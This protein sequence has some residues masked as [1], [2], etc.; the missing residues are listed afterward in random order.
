MK[1]HL[2]FILL[3]IINFSKVEAQQ[4]AQYSQYMNNAYVI[5]PAAGGTEDFMDIKASI[6]KQWVGFAGSPETYYVT[7][8]SPLGRYSGKPH[9]RNKVRNFHTLGGNIYKDVTGPTS[10][11][12]MYGSYSY[13]M[14]LT[15]E[16]RVSMGVFLG[17]QQYKLD[18]NKL[19]F[20]DDGDF[21]GVQSRVVPDGALGSW[22]YSDHF[23]LGLTA[24]QIFQSKLNFD[25]PSGSGL[26]PKHFSKL[27][28]HYFIMGGYKFKL[29]EEWIIVPS[30]LVKVVSP[31]PVSIDINAKVRFKD[32]FWFGASY[33]NLDSF[34]GLVGVTLLGKIDIGYS[35]D[36]TI[37]KINSYSSGSHE[38]LVGFRLKPQKKIQCPSNFW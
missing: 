15:S 36:A 23:F 26:S 32:L 2:I 16:I 34:V 19:I 10:R 25:V 12:G 21:I 8:H 7:A 38:I 35:Y 11:A 3:V 13:N 17:A 31:A 22:L 20:H 6:R 14:A 24:A 33:R 27:S 29:N 9:P 4:M 30:A 37:S 1:L 28:N 18:G 5:N